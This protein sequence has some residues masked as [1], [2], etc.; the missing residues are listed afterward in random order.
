MNPHSMLT[1]ENQI[2]A[3]ESLKRVDNDGY[4]YYMEN[5]WNYYDLK[6]PLAAMLDAGCST[7]FAKNTEGEY[8][9]YRNYDYRHNYLND[10]STPLTGIDV[11]CRNNN[12]AAKYK[13][14][15]CSDA[16]WL[17]YKNG[18]YR[19][20]SADDGKTDVS[21]FVMIPYICMDGVNEAG[22][23][24]SI[25]ALIV[26][27]DWKEIDYATYKDVLDPKKTNYKLE[28]AGEEPDVWA[29]KND[30]GSVAYNDTDKKAWICEKP[31]VHTD[32]P[33]RKTVLHPVLM[34]MM[35]D[36]CA[37]VNEA[38]G[39]AGM[40][41][42]TA[43]APGMDF[44]IMVCDASGNCKVLEWI[45]NQM[46]IVDSCHSTNYRLSAD[47]AFHGRCPRD[48]ALK[49]GLAIGEKHGLRQDF[50]ELALRLA[51]QDPTVTEDMGKTQYSCIYNLNRKTLK[52]YSYGNFEHSWN[53][54]LDEK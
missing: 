37:N 2:K 48:E 26:K 6:G 53:Y 16:F 33:G 47:D 31:L 12:P 11:V 18:N 43:P 38:L 28:K 14:I 36:N 9:M 17:D 49:A 45:G 25:M 19:N 29:R 52:V 50:G 34:R 23:S 51:V 30:I 41:N 4:L 1:D 42:V 46:N 35:L 7:F 32:L 40:F 20:G 15:G 5:S 22:L 54:A 10:R 44:H 39:L 8:L 13:S 3:V 27:A 24:V 21:P